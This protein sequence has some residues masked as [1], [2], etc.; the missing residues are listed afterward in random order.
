MSYKKNKA[1]IEFSP[2]EQ[3]YYKLNTF[4]NKNYLIS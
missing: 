3:I 2:I 4:I 1:N